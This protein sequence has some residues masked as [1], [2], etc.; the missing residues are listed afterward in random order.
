MPTQNQ[1]DASENINQ[2]NA[3]KTD[4]F[5]EEENRE[6]NQRTFYSKRKNLRI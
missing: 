5:G 2:F 6:R 1:R 3:H 4:L